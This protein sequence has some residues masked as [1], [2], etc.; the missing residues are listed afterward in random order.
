MTD[1]VKKVN[2][3]DRSNVK[4]N[5]HPASD[6]RAQTMAQRPPYINSKAAFGFWAKP[7]KNADN[8]INLSIWSVGIPGKE[9]TMWAGILL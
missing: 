7:D 6:R 5:L 4:L 9:G 2:N 1:N 8:S 3:T